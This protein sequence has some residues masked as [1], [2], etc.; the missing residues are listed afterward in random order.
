MQLS[1]AALYPYLS[2]S[3]WTATPSRTWGAFVC[4]YGVCLCIC[5]FDVL[6]LASVFIQVLL[7]LCLCVCL[8][9]TCSVTMLRVV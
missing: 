5:V 4:V 3:L 8:L 9:L 7:Y 6:D 2:S 1:L